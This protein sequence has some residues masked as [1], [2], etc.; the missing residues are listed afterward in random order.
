LDLGVV[1]AD[2]VVDVCYFL[3]IFSNDIG[4]VEDNM[5]NAVRDCC[6]IFGSDQVVNVLL[7]DPVVLRD[8]VLAQPA[9]QKDRD[10]EMSAKGQDH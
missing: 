7:K 9:L 5:L 2:G 1:N 4:S 10:S 8:A 3:I 6:R